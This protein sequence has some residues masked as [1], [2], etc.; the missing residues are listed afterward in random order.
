MFQDTLRDPEKYESGVRELLTELVSG[1]KMS[2]L[3]SEEMALLD[4]AVVDLNRPS[5]SSKPSPSP[6]T[7]LEKTAQMPSSEGSVLRTIDTA[8]VEEKVPDGLLP[9]EEAVPFWF[10]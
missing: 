8:P 4:R 3:S 9:D 5:S 2:D 7:A 6:E 1:R 10:R